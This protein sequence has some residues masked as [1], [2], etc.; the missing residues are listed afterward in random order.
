MFVQK[1]L[2]LVVSLALSVPLSLS[3]LTLNA[4]QNAVTSD[5]MV[6]TA[7]GFE[8]KITNAPASISVI[9]QK[10]LQ[11]KRYSNLADALA[12]VEGVDVRGSTGKTGGLNISIRGMP[13][14]YTL[15][16]IDGRRQN[17]SGNVTP[18]GFG[19]TSTSFIPPLSAIERIEVI[20]G[21]M[22]T[23]YGSDAMGGVINIITRKVSTDWSTSLTL[24][25]TFQENSRAGDTSNLNFYT[26]G[27]LIKE[28]LGLAVRGSIF[29][30]EA[31]H[32]TASGAPDTEIST[33]GPSPVKSDIYTL[34]G[35][36]TYTPTAQHDIWLDLD[37]AKQKY[38]NSN[39]ELGTLDTATRASGYKDTLRF[40][41][42]QASIGHTSRFEAGVLES[43]LMYKETETKGRTIASS[44][45]PSRAGEDRELT[46]TDLIFDTKFYAPLFDSH[47][48][49]I[50]GQWWEA[51][52]KDGLVNDK[53]RQTTRALFVEDEWQIVDNLLFTAGVR[54]DHHD[55]FG[56]HYSPRGYLVW[57]ATE[58]WTFKGGVSRGYKT[59]SLNDLHD[60]ING[61][62]GQG[63]I[64][65]IGNPNL[66]PEVSTNTEFGVYYNHDSG[67]NA[68]V[69]L[70]HNK[71]KDK[72]SSGDPL[73]NCDYA[74]VAG[75]I[76]VSGASAS[77]ETFGQNINIDEAVTQGVEAAATFPIMRDLSLQLNYTYTD[78]EQKSG[79]NQGMRLTNVPR[80]MANSRL[81][82][83]ATEELNLWFKAEYR[84]DS[85]RF[86]SSYDN[87]TA[88]N[89]ALYDTVGNLKGY[90]VFHLGGAYKVS[91]NV[92]LNAGI[93][94]L[95]DKDFLNY[96]SYDYNG[97]TYYASKYSQSSSS[98]SGVMQEGRRYWISANITF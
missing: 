85:D 20:R 62:S 69:T 63:T 61:V 36:L 16:L 14:E 67:F 23:L 55:A 5:V 47:M 11:E 57:N 60:G 4:A 45:I 7:S 59:P 44:A 22:S 84:S 64:I 50:G 90:T 95:F 18:N 56:G 76:T 32:L 54:Y 92:T 73:Y 17:S 79:N 30:R 43:S 34:G 91:Q 51:G 72:I 71:F 21:P 82:W 33:R 74:T 31:S 26:S 86:S 98:T 40:E 15:V 41:R 97:T 70:F 89:K 93:Y 81:N 37:K 87:L 68:N 53:Y 46:S 78:S 83:N 77:Q 25:H 8:Q 39:S 1:K 2:P 58:A 28:Q 80:H 9:S 3:P 94:N 42:Q 6:V 29:N 88:Q 66:K 24:D 49:T 75:C 96:Q 10:D 12:D 19:E 13:S 38:D 27:P 48:A 65:T 35:R 52:M